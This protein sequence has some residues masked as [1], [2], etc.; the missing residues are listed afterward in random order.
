M[1]NQPK[2]LNNIYKYCIGMELYLS[3]KPTFQ[4][5]DDNLVEKNLSG[6]D[7]CRPLYHLIS[8]RRYNRECATNKGTI[9]AYSSTV[10]NEY[11]D[12]LKL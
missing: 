7:N 12:I 2:S 6:E 4:N 8:N 3:F 9:N 10:A 11:V 1:F 5:I